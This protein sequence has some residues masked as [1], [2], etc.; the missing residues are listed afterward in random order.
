M[1]SKISLV[2]LLALS[3][4]GTAVARAD[5]DDPAKGH[6]T[7]EEATKGLSGSGPLTAKIETTLGTFTCELYDKQAPITV[8]NFV[9]L[10]RGRAPLEGPQERQVGEEAVLRRAHLPAAGGEPPLP[11]AHLHRPRAAQPQAPLPAVPDQ[12]LPG[13]LRAA[14]LARGVR[15]SGA[16]RAAVSRRQERRAARAAARAHAATPRR[17]PSSRGRPRSATRSGRWRC[18]WRSSGWCRATSSIRTWSATTA[19]GSRSRSW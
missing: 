13:P 1:R 19:R 11:A 2:V 18:R 16:R 3:L 17:G 9:G 7:L 10:A 5:D 15:R 8:A 14:G 4:L 12:A 6:F